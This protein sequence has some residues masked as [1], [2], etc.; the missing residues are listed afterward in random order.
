MINQLQKLVPHRQLNYNEALT[1]AEQQA[2]RLRRML[3]INYPAITNTELRSIPGVVI[4]TVPNLK[5]AGATRQAGNL[6]I[7]IINQD[8]IAPRQRFT[9]G[10]EL[11]HILDH[12]AHTAIS[13]PQ[14]KWFTERICDYFAACLLMPRPW[15]KQA[16]TNGIQ[17][18]YQLAEAFDVSLTA[19]R[20]RLQQIGLIET[21]ERCNT[22]SP[23]V[24]PLTAAV[25]T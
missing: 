22:T 12:Q 9:I 3:H 23:D 15:I 11:K 7:I 5:V 1:L 13:T 17:D 6:W 14:P 21:P 19:T 25:G 4:E 16:W 18:L 8:D 10:H 2:Q 24:V 20:I